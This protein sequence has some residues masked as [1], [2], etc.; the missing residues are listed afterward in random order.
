MVT[1]FAFELVSLL[2]NPGQFHLHVVHLVLQLAIGDFQIV[3]LLEPLGPAV[4]CVATV[5]QCASFLLQADHLIAWTSVQSLVELPY[6][7]RHEH[8]VVDQVIATAMRVTATGAIAI[9]GR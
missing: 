3:A 6:R 7:K 4:L 2:L 1:K 9:S 8:I 5:L